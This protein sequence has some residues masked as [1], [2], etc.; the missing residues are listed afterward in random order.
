MTTKQEIFSAIGLGSFW[1]RT[2]NDYEQLIIGAGQRSKSQ[3]IQD[4]DQSPRAAD[5][6]KILA[7]EGD[8]FPDD[9]QEGR[10]LS[11]GQSRS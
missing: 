5:G 11:R 1:G 8:K 6:S 4:S 2:W 7:E 9:G 3:V 10:V